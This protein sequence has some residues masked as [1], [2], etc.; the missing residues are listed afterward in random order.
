MATVLHPATGFKPTR[1][2]VWQR[3]R[4]SRSP[5]RRKEKTMMSDLCGYA[6]SALVLL[7]FL[8]R[9]MRVLRIIAILSNIAFI[10]YGALDWLPPV[11]ILH[12]LLLPLNIVRLKE[13]LRSTN[14]SH[15][16]F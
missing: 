7:T 10:I 15:R 9:N 12:T 1:N 11:L 16:S 6:A 13:L 3:S 8:T 5:A 14:R 2:L 4:R